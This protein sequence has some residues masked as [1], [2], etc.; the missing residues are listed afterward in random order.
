MGRPRAGAYGPGAGRQSIADALIAGALAGGLAGL[1]E[2]AMMQIH[3]FGARSW[4]SAV[5]FAAASSEISLPLGALLGAG[6]FVVRR[7]LPTGVWRGL[8]GRVIAGWIYGAGFVL[9]LLAAAYFRLFLYLIANFRNLS[10]AALASAFLSI[11]AAVSAVG[12]AGFVASVVQRMRGGEW[13][14]P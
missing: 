4:S 11:A 3:G 7:L 12:C 10:L 14:R 5:V 1:A 2:A 8:D 13:A 9:P 6:L